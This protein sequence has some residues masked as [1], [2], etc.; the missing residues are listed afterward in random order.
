MNKRSSL[1]HDLL[2]IGEFSMDYF[3]FHRQCDN[4]ALVCNHKP[5]EGELMKAEDYRYP[6]FTKLEF[7][8]VALC[9]TC[10]SPLSMEDLYL[11]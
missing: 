4:V 9:P 3:I 7:G 2:I 5:I 11:K 10:R 6:N 1:G 8:E